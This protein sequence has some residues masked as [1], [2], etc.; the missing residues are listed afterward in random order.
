MWFLTPLMTLKYIIW[1]NYKWVL[2]KALLFT[3]LVAV[4]VLFF[5]AMPGATVDKMFGL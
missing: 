4:L 5:Y 2:L 3:L 1:K